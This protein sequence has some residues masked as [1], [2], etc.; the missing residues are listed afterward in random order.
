MSGEIEHEEDLSREEVATYFEEVAE[1]LRSGEEFTVVLGDLSI[2]VNPTEDV[3][4]EVEVEDEED[5][6]ELSFDVEWERRE[7]EIEIDAE[8]EE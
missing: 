7:D 3:E 2:D 4:F 8:D 1:G 6:R 5:E